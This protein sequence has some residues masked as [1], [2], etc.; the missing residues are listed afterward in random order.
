MSGRIR[1]IAI[2]LAML[3]AA[4]PWPAI[5]QG[6]EPTVV[7]EMQ[8]RSDA[9]LAVKPMTGET[10]ACAIGC[11]RA[12]AGLSKSRGLGAEQVEFQRV[13][14]EAAYVKAGFA[15]DGAPATIVAPTLGERIA[16]MPGKSGYC[17]AQKA[18]LNCTMSLP[19]RNDY[20][21]PAGA[22][23]SAA[24]CENYCGKSAAVSAGMAGR[25]KKR[26]S[27]TLANCE[28]AYDQLH[29]QGGE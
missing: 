12:A 11:G 23:A 9:C 6:A 19:T 2:G 25:D 22:C 7:Q 21:D 26:A 14:C 28:R 29:S 17:A 13:A 8:Q 4:G 27:Y 16:A 1:S 5:A 3:G 24:Q 20:A 10:R 18:A 15:A